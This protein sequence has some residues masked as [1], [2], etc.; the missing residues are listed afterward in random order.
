M[1]DWKLIFNTK[2]Y[3]YI[4]VRE[5]IKEN[6]LKFFLKHQ[7]NIE[8]IESFSFIMP[9]K[10]D[11]EKIVKEDYAVRFTRPLKNFMADPNKQ[12]LFIEEDILRSIISKEDKLESFF[13]YFQKSNKNIVLFHYGDID[14]YVPTKEFSSLN[15]TENELEQQYYLFDRFGDIKSAINKTHNPFKDPISAFNKIQSDN[16]QTEFNQFKNNELEEED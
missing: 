6:Y 10:T 2:S 8:K 16:Q 13:R 3:F 1:K 5:D 15:L 7:S 4:L 14:K 12:T 11:L 9:T